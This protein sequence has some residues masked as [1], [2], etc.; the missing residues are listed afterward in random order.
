MAIV[1]SQ[2][3]L[4]GKISIL[5]IG[6]VLIILLALIGIFIFPGASGSI[7]Q[8]KTQ[9][10]EVEVVVRV[11]AQNT[12]DLLKEGDKTSIII[13]NQ[14]YGEVK[15]KSVKP[16]S[17]N[18]YIPLPDGKVKSLPDPRPEATLSK[19]LLVILAGNAQITKN[20]PVLGNNKIKIG[21][22]IELEGFKYNFTNLNVRDVRILDKG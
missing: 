2:G 13:R 12:E 11:A 5:D 14:P 3:R 7:A 4:F 10:V 6:A 21:T 22:P 18:V 16:L 19:N 17:D 15:I 8:G 9:P 1:D 20:G